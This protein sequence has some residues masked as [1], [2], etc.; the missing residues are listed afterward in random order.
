MG[1][2]RFWSALSL[3]LVAAPSWAEDKYYC[4]VVSHPYSNKNGIVA[5]FFKT[6]DD[7]ASSI[8]AEETSLHVIADQR[9]PSRGGFTEPLALPDS[10]LRRLFV[11]DKGLFDRAKKAPG[12]LPGVTQLLA[13]HNLETWIAPPGNAPDLIGERFEVAWPQIIQQADK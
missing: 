5:V 12:M 3:V 4:A 7:L 1:Q 11:I 13:L 10:H 9:Q 6:R 2:L 8:K